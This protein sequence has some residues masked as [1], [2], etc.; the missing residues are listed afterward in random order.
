MLLQGAGLMEMLIVL[1]ALVVALT[2]HELCHGLAAY[3]LGD[4][5]AKNDGRLSLNP[6]RHIDP[7]GLICILIAGF[8]WAK[9]VMVDSRNLKNERVGMALVAIAGP[10]SNF[11]IAFLMMLI[12]LFLMY[13]YPQVMLQSLNEPSFVMN[14][15]VALC[16]INIV[17][18]VFNLIPLPPLDGSKV[19]AMFLPGALWETWMRLERYG[20]ILLLLLVISGATGGIIMTPA[21]WIFDRMLMGA[22]GIMGFLGV[23]GSGGIRR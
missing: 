11:I 16:Q 9:P 12:T 13:S 18:G 21:N 4:S 6:I 8:G 7:I 3:A 1:P 20:M 15:L 2:I 14:A 17:L 10:L 22:D 5:T 23:I 19:L